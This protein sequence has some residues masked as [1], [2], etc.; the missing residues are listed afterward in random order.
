MESFH[1]GR[2]AMT[3]AP[4]SRTPIRA[5]L[6]PVVAS[7]ALALL[8][9]GGATAQAQADSSDLGLTA[10]QPTVSTVNP[11]VVTT[12][13]NIVNR[14]PSTA[15][16]V[17]LV[18]T[19]P[20]GTSLTSAFVQA[21]I[22]SC[23]LDA[24]ISQVS[25]AIGPLDAGIT[26]SASVT[27][28]NTGNPAGTQLTVQARVGS[29]TPDPVDADNSAS[30]VVTPQ[31]GPLPTTP[32]GPSANLGLSPMLA[33]PTQPGSSPNGTLGWGLFNAGPDEAE[34]VTVVFTLPEGVTY[35]GADVAAQTPPCPF[36]PATREATCTLPRPFASG[37]TTSAA[38]QFTVDG[39]AAGTPITVVATVRSTTADPDLT[40]NVRPNTF[41]G[42]PPP[43]GS[44]PATGTTSTPIA[45]IAALV[46]GAGIALVGAARRRQFPG[47][48]P[49]PPSMT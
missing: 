48:T 18:V 11:A 34:G 16:N 46:L 39:A 12:F 37:S 21:G 3:R 2:L 14:G 13:W 32:T 9:I 33:D 6:W 15:T 43:A 17:V 36:D 28:A 40:D 31:G 5:R 27:I 1:P 23:T 20:A 25:C 22:P 24:A 29:D 7:T 45:I 42:A 4:R 30:I 44:V 38:V 41:G 35:I 8:T 26:T 49:A 10:G 19:L 47:A